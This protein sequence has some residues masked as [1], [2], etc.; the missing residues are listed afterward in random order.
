[1]PKDQLNEMLFAFSEEIRLRILML[2]GQEST[3]CVKCIVG[4]IDAP[5]PTVSRHLS[6]LRRSGMVEVH[7]DEQ[8]RYYSLKKSGPLSDLSQGIAEFFYK[9]LRD[10]KPF[11]KDFDRLKKISGVCTLDCKVNHK[12]GAH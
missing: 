2:L 9:S 1:M 3:L 5:Q 8:H 11:K 6:I 10:K 7:K 4:V 12:S